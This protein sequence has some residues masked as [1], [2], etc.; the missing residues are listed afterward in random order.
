MS[1]RASMASGMCRLPVLCVSILLLALAITAAACRKPLR[2]SPALP[3]TVKYSGCDSV[4][5]G[6]VCILSAARTIRVF[7]S[8][9][10]GIAPTFATGAG[11]L[12]AKLLL[13]I[14]EGSLYLVQIP[15]GVSEISIDRSLPR[16]LQHYALRI[17]WSKSPAWLQEAKD[18][19]TRGDFDQASERLKVGLAST[20]VGDR[21]ASLGLLARIE[22]ARGRTEASFPLFREAME[23]D[24]QSGRLSDQV[25]DALALAYALNQRSRR[26]TEAREVLDSLVTLVQH[27]P[28]GE[29]RLPFYRGQLAF[30]TGDAR[31]ALRWLK[32]AQGAARVLGLSKLER[33]ARSTFALQKMLVGRVQEGLDVLHA[34]ERQS[35]AATDVAPCEKVEWAVNLAYGSLLGAEIGLQSTASGTAADKPLASLER[36]L[37]LC[38]RECRD[39]YTRSAVLTLLSL[40]ALQRSEI[41]RARKYLH[42]AKTGKNEHRGSFVSFWLDCEARIELAAHNPRRALEL[43]NEEWKLAEAWSLPADQWRAVTGRACAMEALGRDSEAVSAYETAEKLLEGL[44]QLVPLGEGKSTMLGDRRQSAR[45]AVA[46]LL[47]LKRPGDALTVARR[48]RAR[49]LSSVR[50]AVRLEGLSPMDRSRWDKAVAAYRAERESIDAESASDWKASAARLAAV[51]VAR[52]AKEQALRRQLDDILHALPSGGTDLARRHQRKTLRPGEVLLFFYPLRDEW[53]G[54][55]ADAHEVQTYLI[56]SIDPKDAP[57]ELSRKVLEPAR[58]KI[59]AAKSITVL[60]Y[61]PLSTLD[62]HS[63]PWENG[64]LVASVPVSYSLDL[65]AAPSLVEA[66]EKYPATVVADPNGTLPAARSE[67]DAVVQTLSKHGG[68]EVSWLDGSSATLDRV[69]AELD[70]AYLFHYAGHGH[71]AG[72]E[73]WDSALPVAQR[74][75][76]TL[77]DVL[78]RSHVPTRVVLSGC[79]TARSTDDMAPEAFGISQAFIVA[80]THSVI[81]ASRRVSDDL[82][83]RMSRALYEHGRLVEPGADP[84]EALRAAQ[85]SVRAQTPEADWSVFR[86]V[87]P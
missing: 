11:Q 26:Y 47:R 42:E 18:L 38:E 60:P 62:F 50:D 34:L 7:L 77:G 83:F 68:W 28:D 8:P 84:A 29:A 86:V 20:D 79:D 16:G 65:D 30:E 75:R 25:D 57:S 72:H 69:S 76:I 1:S 70:R 51:Q 74:G 22:L 37:S 15:D 52:V 19:R 63:L 48:A 80:G 73:G 32:E 13:G 23:L 40:E 78:A 87:Q 54:F 2:P 5:T 49:V 64:P 66:K 17:A 85:N 14:P 33:N 9:S 45:R 71:F 6:P 55:A 43:F 46:L 61:G 24:A 58:A 44:G 53:V 81:A 10:D 59:R 67:G 41:D 56:G 36:A 27:Y 39:A 4:R 31:S 82:A 21:A 3:L 12:D 35:E